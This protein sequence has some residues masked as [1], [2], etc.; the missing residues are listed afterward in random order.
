[1]SCRVRIKPLNK[2]QYVKLKAGGERKPKGP[3]LASSGV[4]ERREREERELAWR[5]SELGPWDPLPS[6]CAFSLSSDPAKCRHLS[7]NRDVM[8]QDACLSL[9]SLSSKASSPNCSA[10]RGSTSRRIP[11]GA[12]RAPQRTPALSV[13]REAGCWA[14][15]G[16]AGLAM[17]NP[18]PASGSV[19]FSPALPPHLPPPPPPA[20]GEEVELDPEA[21]SEGGWGPLGTDAHSL[22]PQPTST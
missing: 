11:T 15:W 22:H 16:S 10:A 4:K 14:G 17:P 21:G 6:L 19:L 8:F 7:G 18:M 2:F 1:M 13:R 12:S 5:V 9:Q 20:P 3:T